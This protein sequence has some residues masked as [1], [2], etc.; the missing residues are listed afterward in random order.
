MK[1]DGWEQLDTVRLILASIVVVD[2][3]AGI[4][5]RPFALVSTGI[6]EWLA[7]GA[8]WAV[9]F[10]FLISGLVIGRS[11]NR[12]SRNGDRLFVGFMRRRI[13]RI[14]PPLLFSVFLT[15][16]FAVTLQAIGADHYVG[17]ATELTR[18]SFSYLEYWSEVAKSLATFGFR[19]S[20]HGS[21]NGPLWSLTLEMQAYV[22]RSFWV[23]LASAIGVLI[24]LRARG[25]Q[26]PELYQ[27]WC[28]AWFAAGVGISFLPLRF[29]RLLPVVPV[30]FSYSLYILHF[31]IMLFIFFITCQGVP[32]P[33]SS[34]IGIIGIA[35]LSV[36]GISLLSGVPFERRAWMRQVFKIPAAADARWPTSARGCSAGSR[37]S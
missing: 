15:V 35:F 3:A 28:F 14:Y 8:E 12:T 31:P 9:Y 16:L 34:L 21:S 5:A 29:P 17:P 11:L 18:K 13:A 20:L 37:R 36:I 2:H 24:A 23:R 7:F 4:F 33:P 10:F 6:S 1:T 22:G 25:A 19:G 30:D 27:V 32:P 26:W